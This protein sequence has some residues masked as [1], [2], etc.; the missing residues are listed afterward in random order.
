M[1]KRFAPAEGTE[2]GETRPAARA[3]LPR[4]PL[5]A[6]LAAVAVA[7]LVAGCSSGSSTASAASGTGG[8]Q[9]GASAITIS[10][11]QI[12]GVG[13]VLTDQSGKTLYSPEQEA[14]GMIKCTG[15]CLSFWFP[16]TVA[17]GATPRAASALTGTLSSIQRP[18]GGGRQLTYNGK[19]LYT[20]RLDTG[21]G[22]DHGNDFT[23]HFGGLTFNWHAATA[24]AATSTSAPAPA[25]AS[26]SASA[27]PSSSSGY[28]S[29]Q[30]GAG[31]Y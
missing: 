2:T 23:D 28:G 20:F 18:D 15:A 5:V 22:Q 31:G 29:S 7:G 10:T 3:R 8:T 6:G 9:S 12:T 30:G 24:S 11:R 4:S 16:V 26:A 19:P 17:K 21:P 1:R 13:T 25:P 27:Q 14:S